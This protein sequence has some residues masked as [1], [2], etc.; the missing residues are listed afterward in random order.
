MIYAKGLYGDFEGERYYL[1]SSLEETESLKS[2]CPKIR[3]G[4]GMGGGGIIALKI[5]G[6]FIAF[7][8]ACD[9][10]LFSSHPL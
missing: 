5:V 4:M 8:M 6:F 7:N 3:Q 1:F 10:A 2:F 9:K